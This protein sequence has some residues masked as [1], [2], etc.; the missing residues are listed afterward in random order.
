MFV[1]WTSRPEEPTSFCFP[2]ERFIAKIGVEQFNKIVQHPVRV[3]FIH[4]PT[5][6]LPGLAKTLATKNYCKHT[7]KALSNKKLVRETLLRF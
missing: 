5:L 3:S 7:L 2:P 4:S 6:T 1:R